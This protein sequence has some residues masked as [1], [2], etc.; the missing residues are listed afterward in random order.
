MSEELKAIL[1]LVFDAIEL[2]KDG[3][4]KNY[5]QLMSDAVKLMGDM[6]MVVKSFS[7]VQNEILL[8]QD[9]AHQ[10]D[11]LAFIR[12][13]FG[14]SSLNQGNAQEVLS[15]ALVL[16]QHSISVYQGVMDLK[17]AIQS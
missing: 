17:K 8:L 10:N 14:S 12:A 6:P 2:G 1:A 7:D 9:P 16:V 4:S 13:K 3:L 5:F 11:L 15:C